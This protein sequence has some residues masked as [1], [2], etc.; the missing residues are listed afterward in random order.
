[1]RQRLELRRRALQQRQALLHQQLREAAAA[2]RLEL[3]PRLTEVARE[4]SRIDEALQQF[5]TRG[6]R[7]GAASA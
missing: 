6:V 1:L 7:D 3:A 2:E 5:D 4:I